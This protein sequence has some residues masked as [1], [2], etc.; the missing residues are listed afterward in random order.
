MTIQML[1]ILTIYLLLLHYVIANIA[2]SVSTPF[3][4]WLTDITG[5]KKWPGLDPP[6]IPNIKLDNIPE[7]SRYNHERCRTRWGY[8]PPKNCSFDCDGCCSKTDIYTCSTFTQTFDDGPSIY[9]NQLLDN[10][11]GKA[12]FFTIGLN[13]AT[14]PDIFKRMVNEGHFIGTHTWSH[15]HLP[16]LSN[17]QIAAQLQWSIWI[18]NATAGVIPKYFRPPYGGLD[19]RVRAVSARL[20]L[21]PIVWNFDTFD[22]KL[23]KNQITEE[24]ILKNVREWKK[25]YTEGII[26]EHDTAEKNVKVA[27][28]INDI[29][30]SNQMKVDTCLPAHSQLSTIKLPL[31]KQY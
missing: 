12:N 18:M 30:G 9:T 29:I 20:N 11:K 13:I 14:Y 1:Q 8:S 19:N 24:D 23:S 4:Q 26:L 21:T 7:N 5:L 31:D 22:W 3:P 17:R 15:K 27:L 10:F 28:Q 16:S 2:Y 25:K 6:F